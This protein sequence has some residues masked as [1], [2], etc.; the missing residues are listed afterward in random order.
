MENNTE[1]AKLYTKV[2]A[3]AKELGAIKEDGKNDFD[4]YVF[5][6]YQQVNALLRS[7]LPK[8]K[9]ALVPQVEQC[10]EN[11]IA[12]SGGKPAMRSIVKMSFELVDLET[13]YSETRIFFG[14]DQDTKGKSLGQAITECQKRFEMKL[15]HVSSSEA[16]PDSKSVEHG[17]KEKKMPW[18]QV[19]HALDANFQDDGATD[20]FLKEIEDAGYTLEGAYLLKD[21]ELQKDL[22]LK[23]NDKLK[24][25]R[26]I[27]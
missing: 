14:G 25:L 18:R 17:S 24:K 20:I 2:N 22:Y 13:G 16:D 8:H 11:E 9:L 3:I 12:T 4:H 26:N 5:I 15:F 7:L 23:L 21:K 27:K 19:L 1:K 6:T 10:S